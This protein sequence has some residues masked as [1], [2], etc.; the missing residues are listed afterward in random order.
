[1]EE[2][3]ADGNVNPFQSR[4]VYNFGRR[5]G[6]NV[7]YLVYEQENHGVPRPGSRMDYARRQLEWFGHYLRGDP[8]PAWISEGETYQARERVL[9]DRDRCPWSR[10][11]HASRS[12]DDSR[13][14]VAAVAKRG[15]APPVHERKAPRKG[16]GGALCTSPKH[17]SKP[18]LAQ[19]SKS[20]VTR[21]LLDVIVI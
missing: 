16:A 19:E 2:G 11:A 6:K 4:E 3:D 13:R 5:L 15:L 17:V 1:M 18:S 8:A 9:K 12:A 21:S 10:H 20:K 7:V 14:Y